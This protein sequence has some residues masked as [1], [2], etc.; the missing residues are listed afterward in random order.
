MKKF[1]VTL[2]MITV[3]TAANAEKLEPGDHRGFV[4]KQQ[5]SGAGHVQVKADMSGRDTCTALVIYD[6]SPR[7]KTSECWL[8]QSRDQYVVQVGDGENDVVV[9][10]RRDH[11]REFFRDHRTFGQ[12]LEDA[13]VESDLYRA[14]PFRYRETRIIGVGA[15]ATIYSYG[16][17]TCYGRHF[18]PYPC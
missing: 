16:A 2:M 13:V 1:I 17:R 10:D 7:M 18:K 8:S 11:D 5:E 6:D 9:L 12:R 14:P 4:W 15:R 3:C